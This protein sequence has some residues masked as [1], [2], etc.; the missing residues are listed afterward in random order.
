MDLGWQPAVLE[1]VTVHSIRRLL[2]ADQVK[3]ELINKCNSSGWLLQASQKLHLPAATQLITVQN[4]LE[5]E[6]C[7]GDTSWHL[8]Y[9]GQEVWQWVEHQVEPSTPEQAT[10]LAEATSHQAADPDLGSLQYQRLWRLAASSDQAPQL[11]AAVFTGF[12]GEMA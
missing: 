11:E 1:P 4:P 7:S 5:G 2:N 3:Q 6:G 10:H 12:T 8:T 9:L